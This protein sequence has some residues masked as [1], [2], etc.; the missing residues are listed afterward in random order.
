M[1][2]GDFGICFFDECGYILWIMWI[3][4]KEGTIPRSK[5]YKQATP[6]FEIEK[7]NPQSY[8][9]K[10][11]DK[12]VDNVDNYIP[13]NDS[14]IETTS[15]APIVINKSPLVQFCNKKFSISSN[16]EK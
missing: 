8:L 6:T 1:Q 2:I 16:E 13:N 12:I 14:P 3:T 7:N 9:K 10:I 11:V 15:P 4:C 5:A